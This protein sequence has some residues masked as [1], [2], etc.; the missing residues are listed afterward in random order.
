MTR[1]GTP[2]AL[3]AATRNMLKAVLDA[4]PQWILGL[5]SGTSLDGVDVAL[6]RTDGEIV[7]TTG[8]AAFV[9]YAA[10]QT[11]ALTRLMADP[12]GVRERRVPG[13]AALMAEA[14]REV[15]R[16]HAGATAALLA[17]VTEIPLV[18]AYPGQ[19]AAHAPER[20]WTWQLGDGAALARALNR[21]VVW[22]FRSADIEAGGQGAPLAP[23]FHHA[24]VRR[25]GIEGPVAIL[26]IGGVAN[27]TWVD[28]SVADPAAPG[29][30]MAFDTG[31]GNA[32]L[33]DWMA[34]RTGQAYDAGGAAA[35]AGA[36]ERAALSRR[37]ATNFVADFLA[38]PA[39]K[40]LDRNAFNT[41]PALLEGASTEGGA[42]ALTGFTVDC[43][44]A[45]VQ[46]L[47]RPPQRW[48]VCGGGRLNDTMM[49]WLAETLGAPVAPVE[50]IG[51]DGDMLEAQA[52]AYLA[53]RILRDLPISAPGTTG[54][55]SPVTGGRLA[56]PGR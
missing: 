54:C 25:A 23:F 56:L 29:A 10:D 17:T 11:E 37:F 47:P 7:D 3:R 52:F 44:A 12:F 14:G 28:P 27:V 35:A 15:D 49:R 16:L 36:A 39:P 50:A 30:L 48:L 20:R 4:Q 34:A 51:L 26:N 18:I 24:A 5:M 1:E 40:S 46:H 53:A 22:D 33:N 45:A 31:P 9:P 55:P 21:P 19:T 8:P 2:G 41:L 32:L 43:V 42:A 38:R 6:L 13:A